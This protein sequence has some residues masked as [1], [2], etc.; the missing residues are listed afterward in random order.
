MEDKI[1]SKSIKQIKDFIINHSI[2]NFSNEVCGFIG[3]DESKNNFVATLEKNESPD[4]KSFFAIN[5]SNYL[6]FKN[7]YSLLSVFHSHIIGDESP[8]EFDIKMS[9]SCCL[10]FTIFSIN[11]K[12]F[13]IY[14]PK[15]FDYD[16][17]I[18]TRLKEKIL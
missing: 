3:Y 5:P 11:S 12:K 4:P 10:A 18:M 8:S 16:V 9:E 14:E 1:T 15:Y 6:K 2:R 7:T 17:N 13:H